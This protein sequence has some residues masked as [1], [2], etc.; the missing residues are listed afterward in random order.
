MKVGILCPYSVTIPGGVQGQ[1]LALARSLRPRG[2]GLWVFQSNDRAQRFY[3]ARGF[4]EVERTDGR[5]N[6]EREPDVRMVWR[7]EPS[8]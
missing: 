5:D 7:G 8:T 2:L 6:E 4:V 1:V 3:A